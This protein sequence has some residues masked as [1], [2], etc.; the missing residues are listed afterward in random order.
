MTKENDYLI[1]N[2]IENSIIN[3]FENREFTEP[4][5]SMKIIKKDNQ[6]TLIDENEKKRGVK[7]L[8]KVKIKR[9]NEKIKYFIE[10]KKIK[11]YGILR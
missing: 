11:I 5:Y 7:K 8:G 6:I 4:F 1:T 10:F 3:S 9:E 2:I